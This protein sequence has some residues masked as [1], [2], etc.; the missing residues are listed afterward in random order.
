[1]NKVIAF[2]HMRIG[3]KG[4]GK[5]WT[6]KEVKSRAEAAQKLKRKKPIKLKIPGW[7]SLDAE[8]IWKKTVK[9]MKDFEILDNVD[10]EVLALYCDLVIKL[11]DLNHT[12][13]QEG[14]TVLN[15][16]GE[17]VPSPHVKMA[18]SYQRLV[19]QYAGKLGITAEA[20]ARLAK[21]IADAGGSGKGGGT[22]ELFD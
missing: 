12:I 2:D 8:E 6:E 1:L 15:A 16:K 9:D 21:R 17:A 22:N 19:L 14:F 5:H 18:Q 10:E 3:A 4:G 20:R 7:L 13:S 11:Q